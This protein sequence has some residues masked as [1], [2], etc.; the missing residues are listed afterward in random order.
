[1]YLFSKSNRVLMNSQIQ[2]MMAILVL[3][4]GVLLI[5]PVQ[6]AECGS[7]G[8]K[9]CPAYKKGPQ[10]GAWLAKDK[11]KIC[12]PC[13]GLK[14][15]SC[16]VIKK[17]KVCKSGLVKKKGL[18]VAK[19][20]KISCGGLNQK[21]CRAINKGP[22]CKAW[23]AKDKR[24]ICGPCGGLKQ[25]SCPII[26]KGKVC[27]PGLKKKKGICVPKPGKA[28]SAFLNQINSFARKNTK[29]VKALST[30]NK[31]MKRSG[32]KRTLK[33]AIKNKDSLAATKVVNACLTSSIKQTLR[34][35]PRGLSG[36]TGGS[37]QHYFNTLSIG[38]GGGLI[39]G[40]GASGDSG[41]VIS[42]NGDGVRF[43][44]NKEFSYGL[45][46]SAGAD[47]SVGIS[48]QR[49]QV[50]TDK[51]RSVAASGKFIG[52]LGVAVDFSG[53]QFPKWRN[54]DGFGVSGG[55]GAGAEVGTIY[56]STAKVY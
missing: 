5:N 40:V 22:Q 26:K 41:V 21:A 32:R 43:Y 49:L 25:K 7:N 4:F 56:K 9:A 24:K 15:K 37:K 47:L 35:K 45:G 38:V 8:Q 13:G 51:G 42:L 1:M 44:S 36:S 54:F 34:S 18:C 39:I 19:P 46:I 12:R 53:H 6:A 23:L 11:R 10:C 16:P 29:H 27:K 14:Q 2:R 50:G 3:L 20:K 55:V 17:G 33:K 48:R 52:G 28:S 30:L 31:C